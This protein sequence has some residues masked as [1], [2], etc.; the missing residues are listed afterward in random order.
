MT[1]FRLDASI[2]TAGSVSREVA[3]TVV[4]A[5]AETHPDATVVTPRHRHQPAALDRLAERRH[6]RLGRPGRAHPAAARRGR[7]RHAIVDDLIAAD[8][9]VIATPLY[10]Y[11]I[12]QNLKAWIDLVIT[13]PRMATGGDQ[14][15][16]GRPLVLVVARGGGYAPG[17][18]KEGWDHAT[19]YLQRIFGEVFGMD[20]HLVEAELTLAHVVPAMEALRDLADE[21][22]RNAHVTA[23]EHGTH[24]RR[25]GRSRRRR[26][27]ARHSTHHP[28]QHT[29]PRRVVPGDARVRRAAETPFNLILEARP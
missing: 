24:R 27:T 25:E 12:Q 17:T 6:R 8:A 2:R 5:W 18:P 23:G 26:L 7:A 9:Y 22:Q 29:E 4:A 19:P 28:A 21:S 3:D 13:D 11:G 14:P 15:L 16:A 10:N 1:L 20:V